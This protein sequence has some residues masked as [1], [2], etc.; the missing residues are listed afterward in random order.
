MANVFHIRWCHVEMPPA[1]FYCTSC[2]QIKLTCWIKTPALLPHS[3]LL[4]LWHRYKHILCTFWQICIVLTLLNI[5]IIMSMEKENIST[6]LS[7]DFSRSVQPLQ[8]LAGVCRYL[9]WRGLSSMELTVS[10]VSLRFIIRTIFL[11][12]SW[13]FNIL[14]FNGGCDAH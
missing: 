10:I 13:S 2:C 3:S 12:Y 1:W 5:R 11:M 14:S 4:M 9:Q 8:L 7:P 6:T